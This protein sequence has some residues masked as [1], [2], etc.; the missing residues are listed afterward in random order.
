MDLEHEA[1]HS[2]ISVN[3]ILFAI[4]KHKGMILIGSILGIAAAAFVYIT[5]PKA[6]ESEAKLLVRYVLDRSPV[7][8][9]DGST[10]QS[11]VSSGFGRTGENVIGSE[12]EILTSW[13]LAIQVATAL[14]PKR[15]LPELGDDASVAG[16]AGTI[17]SGL[18]VVTRP[19]SDII[20][21]TY[22]NRDPQLAVMVLEELVNRYFSKHLEVHRSS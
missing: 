17:S 2:A 12:A 8:P 4:F 13:D 16:A 7:D 21:V 18:D 19:K 9:I 1:P 3:D 22:K 15:L 20:L 14:G 5:Y 11:S 10:A 6:Y